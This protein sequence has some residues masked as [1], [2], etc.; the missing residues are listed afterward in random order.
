M[1]IILWFIYLIKINLLQ[2]IV[3]GSRNPSLTIQYIDSSIF[4]ASRC[5]PESENYSADRAWAN[6][7]TDVP[8]MPEFV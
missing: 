1:K 8:V 2:M 5:T 6:N 4:E 3:H 7:L